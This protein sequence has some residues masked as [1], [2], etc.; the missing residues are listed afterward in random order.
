M[1]KMNRY[2]MIVALGAVM[3]LGVFVMSHR[4]VLAQSGQSSARGEAAVASGGNGGG[5]HSLLTLS[6]A[7]HGVT[8]MTAAVNANGVVASCFQC[9]SSSSKHLLTGEYQVTF[10]QPVTANAGW[11][12]WVQT[13]TLTNSSLVN[14]A[15]TT[16]DRVGVTSAVYVQCFNGSGTLVDT[17]FFLFVAR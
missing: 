11:S 8:F 7:N 15:C 3:A 16:A 4:S 9:V 2:L 17:P 14:V 5:V 1:T 10:N 13:D 6:Q 12:R